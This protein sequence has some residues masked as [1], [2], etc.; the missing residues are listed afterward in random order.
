[1][2]TWAADEEAN[3]DEEANADG[4]MFRIACCVLGSVCTLGANEEAEAADV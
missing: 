4:Q 3:L 2:S 1:M